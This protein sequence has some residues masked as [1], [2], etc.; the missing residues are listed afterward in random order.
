MEIMTSETFHS[1]LMQSTETI[2]IAFLNR[3]EV[4][5]LNC[6]LFRSFHFPLA[7]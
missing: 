7:R 4:W 1:A 2:Y 3:G 5:E 6:D